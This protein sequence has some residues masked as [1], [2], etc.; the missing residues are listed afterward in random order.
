MQSSQ[1][2]WMWYGVYVLVL[3]VFGIA[4]HAASDRVAYTWRWDRIPQYIVNN[5]GTEMRAPYDGFVAV[6][7]DKKSLTL[8][9]LRGSRHDTIT[10]FDVLLVGD[11][12]L[13]FQNDALARKSGLVAGPLTLGL[14]MTLK[15][16]AVALVFSMLLGLVAGLGRIARNP[17]VYGLATTYVEL[18][19]GTPLLVQIFIFYFFVGTVLKLSAFTAGAAALA[20]FTGA[21]VAEIIR[22]G[23]ESI[24]RG[25]MEA[26]RSLGMSV[27]Q[28]MRH[29]VLPQAFKKTLPPLAGQFI[30]LIKDSSLV[31]VMALTDLT[32]A[33]REVVASTFS[34][35]EVWFTVALMYL[36]LTGTLSL[37]VRRLEKRLAHD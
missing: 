25:Q 15:L 6:A 24:P 17:A 22:A 21:Y 7:P 8:K 9:E 37:F 19:R 23:I 12:D 13:V 31:S 5:D 34:P 16:S 29:V 35:F 26:A 4:V 18:I 33:G 1:R 36:V 11:G 2:R 28:A 10:G 30:N 32:K 27:P 20:V 3:V 14:W